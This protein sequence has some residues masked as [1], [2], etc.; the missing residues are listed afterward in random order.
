MIQ[1][2]WTSV[3][4]RIQPTILVAN[5]ALHILHYT[6]YRN[7]SP[8][9]VLFWIN[10]EKVWL[11]DVMNHIPSSVK[12]VL[13]KTSNR[14]CAKEK[15]TEKLLDGYYAY[16]DK[17]NMTKYEQIIEGCYQTIQSRAVH[18]SSQELKVAFQNIT[19]KQII[20]YCR[21]GTFDDYGTCYRMAS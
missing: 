17:S 4:E 15:F 12:L 16:N 14:I 11:Q 9:R 2:A 18:Q 7:A 13:F 10:Y 8:D 1:E 19:K 3:Q 21:H 5:M 20:E 6:N